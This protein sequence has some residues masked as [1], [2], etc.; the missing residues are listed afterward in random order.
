MA[1]HIVSSLD[2]AR[3][4]QEALAPMFFLTAVAA[5]LS[6]FSTRL[7]RV[8]DHVDR[9]VETLET[10]DPGRADSLNV[11]LA[12]LRHR[13]RLLDA[14]VVLATIAAIAICCAGLA[15]FIGI[16]RDF[17]VEAAGRGTAVAPLFYSLFAAALLSMIGALV[18]FL[19]EMLIASRGLRMKSLNVR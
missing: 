7:A 1:D 10:A 11:Q 16:L 3:V 4:I 14:A 15:L 8:A 18:V 6:A 13:S 19:I 2:V 9:I 5:L 12:Y 17:F